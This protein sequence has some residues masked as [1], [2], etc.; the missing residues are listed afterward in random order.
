MAFATLSLSFDFVCFGAKTVEM[1]M[2]RV[3]APSALIAIATLLLSYFLLHR[4]GVLGAGVSYLIAQAIL[5]S[6]ISL[7]LLKRRGEQK[8]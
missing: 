5:A 8:A 7:W 1:K 3:I 6:G 2:K 4:M